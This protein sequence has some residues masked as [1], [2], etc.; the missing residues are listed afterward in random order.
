[1]QKVAGVLRLD[2]LIGMT[3]HVN[4]DK[5]ELEV[6][7]LHKQYPSESPSQIAHR[8]M[9]QKAITA[10]RTGLLTSLLPRVATAL[11]PL[12]RVAPCATARLLLKGC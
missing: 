10:D 9:M 1:M 6:K 12:F 8:I 11:T 7:Q 4:F 3:N 2:W 5:A